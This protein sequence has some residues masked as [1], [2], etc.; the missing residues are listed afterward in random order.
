MSLFQKILIGLAFAIVT[1]VWYYYLVTL[2]SFKKE[3]L[4]IS[5]KEIELKQEK[6]DL[7]L[8]KER[9]EMELKESE[10]EQNR[11]SILK[12]ECENKSNQL[13]KEFINVASVFF[14]NDT[15]ECMVKSYDD[16]W[17]YSTY[18]A[19]SIVKVFEKPKP[20]PHYWYQTIIKWVNLREYP[21]DGKIIQVIDQSNEVYIK[22]SKFLW[23][24]LWYNVTFDSDKKWWISSIAFWQ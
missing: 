6:Q 21:P 7:D 11:I 14:D 20:I 19:D 8:E 13:K 18:K 16:N 23:D 15:E 5:L 3:E 4:A 22:D 12:K 1:I 24:D 17:I 9:K 2:P 10:Q